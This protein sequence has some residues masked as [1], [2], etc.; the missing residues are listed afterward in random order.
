MWKGLKV[1]SDD[2]K[3]LLLLNVIYLN[4]RQFKGELQELMLCL[5]YENSFNIHAT[6]YN[7]SNNI[8]VRAQDTTALQPSVFLTGIH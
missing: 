2:F 1:I 6:E 7:K 3:I 5:T 8:N 4:S